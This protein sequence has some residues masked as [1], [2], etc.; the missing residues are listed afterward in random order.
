MVAL[1]NDTTTNPREAR[2]AAIRGFN[3]FYT[4]KVG[5][6][7]ESL[8]K[9]GFSLAEGRVLYEIAQRSRPTAAELAGDLRLDPGYLS[10]VLRG[11]EER[12]LI[13]RDASAA[14][15]RQSLLSLTEAGAEA[16]GPLDRRSRDDVA[17]W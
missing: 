16:F 7:D 17:A 5:A 11:L 2:I 15:Q 12:R 1:H 6:L 10:R 14:D 3:R 4:Q 8:L 13:R 9:S